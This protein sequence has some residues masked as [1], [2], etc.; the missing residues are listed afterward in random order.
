[1]IAEFVQFMSR[2]R[3]QKAEP[4]EPRIRGVRPR[5]PDW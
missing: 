2:V 3:I 4:A 1:M 5:V